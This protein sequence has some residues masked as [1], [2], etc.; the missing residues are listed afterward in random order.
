VRGLV[1]DAVVTLVMWGCRG[2]SYEIKSLAEYVELH[3]LV[4]LPRDLWRWAVVGWERMGGGCRS[5][6]YRF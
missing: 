4:L 5:M 3:S 2:R 1:C 6:K